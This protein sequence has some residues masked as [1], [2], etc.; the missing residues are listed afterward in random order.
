M[1]APVRDRKFESNFLHRRVSRN[2]WPEPLRSAPLSSA[3]RDNAY[4]ARGSTHSRRVQGAHLELAATRENRAIRGG[5]SAARNC[6][7]EIALPGWPR[8]GAASRSSP[9]IG[10]CPA[11]IVAQSISAPGDTIEDFSTSNRH[12]RFPGPPTFP[13]FPELLVCRHPICRCD[14]VCM[15]RRWRK[16][17]SSHRSP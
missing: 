5:A 1:T 15:S 16:M 3:L 12:L 6:V 2:R 13:G 8:V 10:R 14:R 17:D 4:P 11:R 9:L 7:R